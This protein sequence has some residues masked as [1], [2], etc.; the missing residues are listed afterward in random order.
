MDEVEVLT[1]VVMLNF[2][3]PSTLISL[4]RQSSFPKPYIRP[5]RGRPFCLDDEEMEYPT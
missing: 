1:D 5:S 3:L 4:P 2:P